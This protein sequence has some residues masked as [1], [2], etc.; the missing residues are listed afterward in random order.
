MRGQGV[1]CLPGAPGMKNRQKVIRDARGKG[2]DGCKKWAGG[3]GM[4]QGEK[5][6][7]HFLK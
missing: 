3:S 5:E 6:W 7:V 4:G 1:E 2:E